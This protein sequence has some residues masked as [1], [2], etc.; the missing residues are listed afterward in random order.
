L[1]GLASGICGWFSE[2]LGQFLVAVT[3]LHSRDNRFPLLGPQPLE[4]RLVVFEGLAANRLL[5][6]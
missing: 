1:R 3:H 4:R 2:Y 5:V 6:G